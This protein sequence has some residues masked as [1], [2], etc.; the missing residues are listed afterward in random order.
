MNKIKFKIKSYN[1]EDN[2]VIISFASDVTATNNPDD[3]ESYAFQPIEMYPDIT[4]ME[5]LKKKIAEQGIALADLE[6]KKEDAKANTTMQNNWKALVGQTF[7][8]NVADVQS[9]STEITYTNEIH[10][11]EA[12]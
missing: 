11:P 10:L 7:E 12:E 6:K 1:D 9:T 8:Y 2:S 3:Y 4:D 5:E